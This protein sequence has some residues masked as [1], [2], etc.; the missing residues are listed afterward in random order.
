MEKVW[1][2]FSECIDSVSVIQPVRE[3]REREREKGKREREKGKRERERERERQRDRSIY[4]EREEKNWKIRRGRE[5]LLR[6]R[7]YREI[8]KKW[9]KELLFENRPENDCR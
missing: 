2:R 8:G 4:I 3:R 6:L 1:Y 5:R 7:P 9:D